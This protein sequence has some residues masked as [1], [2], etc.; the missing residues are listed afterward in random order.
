MLDIQ[1]E[2]IQQKIGSAILEI[3]KKETGSIAPLVIEG[4]V[5]VTPEFGRPCAFQISDRFVGANPEL[6]FDDSAVYCV[7]TKK[8]KTERLESG[9]MLER[10][11]IVDRTGRYSEAIERGMTKN[12]RAR[13]DN[14]NNNSDATDAEKQLTAELRF[15]ENCL[16]DHRYCTGDLDSSDSVNGSSSTGSITMNDVK[17][18]G[19]RCKDEES[20]NV[21]KNDSGIQDLSTM[22][23]D[24]S[25][26]ENGLDDDSYE[27]EEEEIKSVFE[28]HK[29]I[30]DLESDSN[31][32]TRATGVDVGNHESDLVLSSPDDYT[33]QVRDVIRRRCLS[34][35][36]EV[37]HNSSVAASV[38]RCD[39]VIPVTSLLSSVAENGEEKEMVPL[40]DGATNSV[41]KKKRLVGILAGM[42]S[43]N[44]LKNQG[45]VSLIYPLANRQKS[46][47]HASLHN[48]LNYANHAASSSSAPSSSSSSS[49][50][51]GSTQPDA[52]HSITAPFPRIVNADSVKLEPVS[53]KPTTTA[54]AEQK[55]YCCTFCQK[56]FLFKSKYLEHLP[57]HTSL[58]PYQ[59]TTCNR[60]YKYKYDLRVHLRTHLGIPT[61]STIC[62]FCSSKFATNKLLRQHINDSHKDQQFESMA[63][64]EQSIDGISIESI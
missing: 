51:V 37:T 59:C 35:S 33:V 48:L 39:S 1:K 32:S 15:S 47:V 50:A 5:C 58:R 45:S 31:H 55:T 4:T 40:L 14:N 26:N 53:E 10:Q 9:M 54:E 64:M 63:K 57:V 16:S 49:F 34:S 6:N 24:G 44:I 19:Q 46:F 21:D 3:W 36:R 20:A 56:T 60:T 11:R 52:I 42:T 2:R 22:M 7:P 12:S 17:A 8:R 25:P 30:E 13:D 62:P 29:E 43:Q 41:V 38:A 27:E 18:V 61:K 28:N 23:M